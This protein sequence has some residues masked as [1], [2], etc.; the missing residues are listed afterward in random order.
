MSVAT[1]EKLRAVHKTA[2]VTVAV[3]MAKAMTRVAVRWYASRGWKFQCGGRAEVA[4]GSRE[5]CAE[6]KICAPGVA[7]KTCDGEPRGRNG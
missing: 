2:M 3:V 4:R 7:P 5:G 6:M 1:I